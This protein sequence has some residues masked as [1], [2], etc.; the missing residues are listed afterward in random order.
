MVDF[1]ERMRGEIKSPDP[2]HVDE[3]PAYYAYLANRHVE[4]E[5][6]LAW[7]EA[8]VEYYAGHPEIPLEPFPVFG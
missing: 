6:R 5:C 2:R 8:M 4:M 1:L 3:L 7:F